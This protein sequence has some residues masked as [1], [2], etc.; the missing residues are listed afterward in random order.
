MKFLKIKNRKY[1]L[2]NHRMIHLDG[3]GKSFKLL[4]TYKMFKKNNIQNNQKY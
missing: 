1:N 3:I 2:I 4:K